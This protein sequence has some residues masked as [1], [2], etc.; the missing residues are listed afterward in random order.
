MSTKPATNNLEGWEEFVENNHI[1]FVEEENV[2]IDSEKT[3]QFISELR[4]QDMKG[5]MG[6]FETARTFIDEIG[7]GTDSLKQIIK[8]YYNK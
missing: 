6:V 3:K 2:Y 1:V 8:E 4:Q 7:F 5:L